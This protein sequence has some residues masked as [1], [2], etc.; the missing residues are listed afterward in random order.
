MSSD[1]WELASGCLIGVGVSSSCRGACSLVYG[2]SLAAVGPHWESVV[3]SACGTFT[4]A[5]AYSHELLLLAVVM[6]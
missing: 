6:V 2:F 1:L 4:C 5:D 3:C